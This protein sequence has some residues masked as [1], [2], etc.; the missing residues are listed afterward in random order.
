MNIWRIIIFILYSLLACFLR[1]FVP[2]SIRRPIQ[3]MDYPL[4]NT[5]TIMTLYQRPTTR[6]H[7]RLDWLEKMSL[8]TRTST[9]TTR[10]YFFKPRF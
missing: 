1:V 2:N 8:I 6:P 9:S 5:T 4:W 7:I 3:R 10:P